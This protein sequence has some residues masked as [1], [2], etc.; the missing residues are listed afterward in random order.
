ML[1]ITSQLLVV[2]KQIPNELPQKGAANL[3]GTVISGF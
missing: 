2:K 1:K 3:E